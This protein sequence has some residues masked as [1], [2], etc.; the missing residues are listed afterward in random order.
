M[1]RLKKFSTKKNWLILLV[2]T[3]LIFIYR[4][5]VVMFKSIDFIVFKSGGSINLREQRNIVMHTVDKLNPLKGE[6][7]NR[8]FKIPEININFSKDDIKHFEEVISKAKQ[9]STYAFYMPNEINE[10]LNTNIQINNR[11]YKSEVKIHGTNN[12]HFNDDKK[13]YSIKIRN[14]DEQEYPFGIRRFALIIPNQSNHIAIFT[15]RVAEMLGMVAPK[16]FLVRLNINGIDQGVYHLEEKLNKT[17]LERNGM[18][19]YDV[20]RSDDSWA[21]QYSDNHGTI[22]S[23][24]YSG[25]QPGYTSGRDL[26]QNVITKELLNSE[27]INF[28]KNNINIDKF[29][30][31]DLLRY[32][33]GDSGHMASNDNIKFLYN[34]SNGRLEPYFRI[35]NHIE[36]IQPNK[37][38]YSPE[39][40][41]NIGAFSSNKLLSNLTRDDTY[42]NLRN[43][44]LYKILMQEEKILDIYKDVIETNLPVLL[45]DTTNILPSRYFRYESNKAYNDLKSN[46]IFLKKYL[47]YSRVF[48]EILKETKNSY[49]LI[50]KPDSNSPIKSESFSLIVDSKHIGEKVSVI[51]PHN[52]SITDLIINSDIGGRGVIDIQ[53]LIGKY[54]YSL[55]LDKDLEPRKNTYNFKLIFAG[56]VHDANLSFINDINKKP[57][58]KRD[59]YISFIDESTILKSTISS[60]FKQVNSSE[61]ILKTGEYIFD[62]D[63]VIPHNFNLLIEKGTKMI[64]DEGVSILIRGGLNIMGDNEQNVIIQSKS[65]NP[66]GVIAA[67]GDGKSKVNIDF[68]DISG[69]SEDIINGIY[70]S[71]AL[72]LY[73]HQQ[74]TIKNSKIHHNFADDGLNIKNAEVLISDNQFYLNAADQF[75]LDTGTGYIIN[76]NFSGSIDKSNQ[77]YPFVIEF[78]SN[79]DGLDLSDSRIIVN[80]NLFEGFVDKGISIGENTKTFLSKNTFR[81]NRSAITAKDQSKV[82]LKE[83]TYT[84]NITQL[85]MYQ[86]KLFFKHPSVFNLNKKNLTKIV[87]TEESNLYNRADESFSLDDVTPEVF[88]TLENIDWIKYQ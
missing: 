44:E 82:F 56:K 64:L 9:S 11:V 18:S 85:E 77:E 57:L 74:V 38:T 7:W 16:N 41:V 53:N 60:P 76:N 42:R 54:D 51:D 14:K 12:P 17:L 72:S 24:D 69:G 86:K 81:N 75:D 67:V 19:G 79:G 47:D 63:I 83:N 28:I 68:L 35:E 8:S 59:T 52:N 2:S 65:K 46:F 13:S 29:I 40:H 61:I 45:N 5:D 78:D 4:S 27:D 88:E 55:G 73:N 33:F 43:R 34:T 62:E 26:N 87:K 71:G 10:S 1:D 15:Y 23:F 21:H 80:Q 84:E 36:E 37:L 50:I 58:L 30:K 3:L 22:F 25:I 48:V 39:R 70:L 20:V 32:I 31:Y 49:D 66:F 6:I